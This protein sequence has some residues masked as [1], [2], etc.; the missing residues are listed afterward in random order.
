MCAWYYAGVLKT[1][2]SAVVFGKLETFLNGAWLRPSMIAEQAAVP[3]IL[4]G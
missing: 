1:V 4:I 3:K 2:K